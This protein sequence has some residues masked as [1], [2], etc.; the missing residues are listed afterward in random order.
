[1]AREVHDGETV[2]SLA[3]A[4]AGLEDKATEEK[5][6]AAQVEGKDDSVYVVATP[7]GGAQSI[8]LELKTSWEES[9]SDEDLLSEI[10]T[11]QK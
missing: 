1:M 11:Q 8:R 10:K 7:N 2:W 3:Q 5:S 6:D 9:L 4:Y